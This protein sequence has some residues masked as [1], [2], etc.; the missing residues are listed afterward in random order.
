[1][2]KTDFFNKLQNISDAYRW[3]IDDNRLVAK[4]QRGYFKGFTLNPIT[5]LAHKSGWGFFHN[6][7]K[8]TIFAA[9]LLGLPRSFA[10]NIYGAIVAK[11]NHGNTQV[12]RGRIRSA[13]EV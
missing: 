5:A 7:K 9:Q 1:M 6:N 4:I 11:N 3:D 10:E 8:D 2:N 13:L 12:V